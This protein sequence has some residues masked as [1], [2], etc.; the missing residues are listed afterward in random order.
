MA[1][2]Y[3]RKMRTWPYSR[4]RLSA[5][6]GT[7]ARGMPMRRTCATAGLGHRG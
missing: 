4:I 5:L 7:V 3:M 1:K 2:I 6:S